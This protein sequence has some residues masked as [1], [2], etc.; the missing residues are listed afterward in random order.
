MYRLRVIVP[1]EGGLYIYA[2]EKPCGT[3][4]LDKLLKGFIVIPA[5]LP[6]KGVKRL[7]T[8]GERLNHDSWVKMY[9]LCR[10][11]KTSILAEF[12]VKSGLE[13]S[14]VKGGDSCCVKY[15]HIYCL[16]LYITYVTL[17]MRLWEL[18]NL[19]AILVEFDMDSL[20]LF[21]PHFRRCFRFVINQSVGS[22]R[23]KLIPEVWSI[24]HCLLPKVISDLLCM[25][26]IYAF[27]Y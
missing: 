16:M 1:L 2:P 14:C 22:Y 9:N 12:M 4:M 7:A 15:A 6:R 20:S 25:L 8:L 17:I 23:E 19:V 24:F 5:D 26:Y 21:P 13:D 18:Y 3:N 11:L 10:V 27:V